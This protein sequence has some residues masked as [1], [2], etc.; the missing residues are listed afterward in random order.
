M[1]QHRGWASAQPGLISQ[2]R[3]VRPPDPLLQFDVY[4]RVRKPVKR[5]GREPSDSAGSTP[6][7]TTS[8]KHARVAQRR[9]RVQ[10]KQERDGSLPSVITE[11]NVLSQGRGLGLILFRSTEVYGRQP[12]TVCRAAL[13]TRATFG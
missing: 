4:G 10:D 12:D 5:L 6:V 9:R 11:A 2:D 7:S 13:L 1:P 3:R 8:A